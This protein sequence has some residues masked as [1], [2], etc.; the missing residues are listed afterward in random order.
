METTEGRKNLKELFL[1][2]GF[3]D[4]KWINPRQQIVVSQWVRMKC[5]FGCP[6]YGQIA[7]CPPNTVSVMECKN[8]FHEYEEGVIFHFEKQFENPEDRHVWSREINLK[9]VELEREVFLSGHVKAFLLFMDSCEICKKCTKVREECKHPRLS[10]PSPEGMAIDV[11]ATVSK[12]GYPIKVLEDYTETMNRYA[13][14][15]VE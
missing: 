13:F 8:F 6:A 15:L 9:L 7:S 12:I 3:K 2:H 10:R 11:F 14:L 4:F 1:N 5:I